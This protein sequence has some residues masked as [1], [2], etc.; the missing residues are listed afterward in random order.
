[1]TY[2]RPIY[3][4]LPNTVNTVF[5]GSRT[6]VRVPNF[7]KKVKDGS[8]AGSPYTIDVMKVL[9]QDPA[10]LSYTEA[11]RHA[12]LGWITPRTGTINGYWL[13]ISQHGFDH[14]AGISAAA[15]AQALNRIYQRVREDSYGANGLLFLGELRETIGM[16]RRP[17][18]AFRKALSKY[19]STLTTTRRIVNRKLRPRKS[20]SADA[21]RLRRAQAVKDAMSG[22]WLEL[23]FGVKPL[24]SDV[25]EISEECV[26]LMTEPSRKTRLRSKSTEVPLRASI[27][28][29]KNSQAFGFETPRFSG[30]FEK[31]TVAT[32]QYVVGLKREVSGPTTGLENVG[33]RLG[34]QIQN[35]VPTAYELLP[36]SFLIDYF[37]N[38]GDI[39]EAVCTD[40]SAISWINKTQR[41][42][43]TFTCVE[44]LSGSFGYGLNAWNPY[45]VTGK[46]TSKRVFVRTT[47]SRTQPSS[48]G[49]P[50]L[51]LSVPGTDSTKWYNM[52]ALLAQSSKFR[53]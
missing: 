28:D 35:F 15:E 18:E 19:L 34:F 17:A 32:V 44:D 42:K 26:R 4:N 11:F 24:I 45:L 30:K 8:Q 51:I 10:S 1:M 22:S 53:F 43:T 5:T 40:T 33:R 31:S 37:V 25:Q 47:L 16:I 38:I 2:T 49:I 3:T 39:L 48:L 9:T 36:W 6:G 29:T 23:Q 14:V 12:T 41:T 21:F 46:K 13:S 52:A 7:R 50:P 20:E 27:I